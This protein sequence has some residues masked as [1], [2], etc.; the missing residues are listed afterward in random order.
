MLLLVPAAQAVLTKFH[1]A[2]LLLLLLLL[3]PPVLLSVLM[4][5]LRVH[6]GS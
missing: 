4:L 2:L 5:V 3:L 6:V 1:E